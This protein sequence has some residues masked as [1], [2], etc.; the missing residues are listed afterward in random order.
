MCS[1][2]FFMGVS[3]SVTAHSLRGCQCYLVEWLSGKSRLECVSLHTLGTVITMH[4]FDFD[5][6]LAD[7]V[8]RC[9]HTYVLYISLN[10]LC[11]TFLMLNGDKN[12]R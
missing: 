10:S 6:T 3:F 11:L 12:R 4:V 1:C 5:S 2:I 8:V 7:R 9:M